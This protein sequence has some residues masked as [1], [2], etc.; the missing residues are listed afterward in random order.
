MSYTPN[1]WQAGDVV[2]PA[3]LNHIEEGI[4]NASTLV[5]HATSNDGVTTLDKTWQEIY[6]ALAAG[7]YVVVP[8]IAASNNSVYSG[9]VESAIYDNI[10]GYQVHIAGTSGTYYTTGTPN[11]YPSSGGIK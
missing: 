9:M 2:T 3:K 5:V 4:A 1:V 6:D 8:L 11:G 10:E 7:C